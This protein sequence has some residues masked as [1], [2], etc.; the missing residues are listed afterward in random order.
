[1]AATSSRD[2]NDTAA[3]SSQ[4]LTKFVTFLGKG[5]SGKTTAAV[6]AAQVKEK[7]HFSDFFLV[8]LINLDSSP[9]FSSTLNSESYN[10]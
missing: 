3:D 6:F 10:V 7:T 4:K 2:V 1:M 9:E 5:G 8:A